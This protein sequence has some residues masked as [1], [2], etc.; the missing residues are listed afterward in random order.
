MPDQVTFFTQ[1]DYALGLLFC[2]P[3]GDKLERKR[4]IVVMTLAAVVAL[5]A[6]AESVNINYAEN[7]RVCLDW[8]YFGSAAAD[9]AT[10][11][12]PF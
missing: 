8:F 3:L 4:Q 10:G 1:V 7:Y 2:V 9:I 12:R 11:S 6:A 5:V